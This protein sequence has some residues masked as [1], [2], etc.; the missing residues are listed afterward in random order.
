MKNNKT[1]LLE[2]ISK[3]GIFKTPFVQ[4]DYEWFKEDILELLED[5]FDIDLNDE[6]F[7]KHE[8]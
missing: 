2:F 1:D 3:T 8:L 7:F 5:I 6:V 4:R